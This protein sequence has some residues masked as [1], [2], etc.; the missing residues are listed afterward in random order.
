M[1]HQKAVIMS[2]RN[3]TMESISIS[4]SS[5]SSWSTWMYCFCYMPVSENYWI[6]F[7]YILYTLELRHLYRVLL[8]KT[9]HVYIVLGLPLGFTYYRHVD[10]R[11]AG[12]H[13]STEK[14]LKLSFLKFKVF[15]WSVTRI[16]SVRISTEHWLLS[17]LML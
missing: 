12:L 8:L 5:K 7:I 17:T 16:S 13:D 3:S 1:I 6:E 11:N 2:K 4:L 15:N 10:F 14:Q 9:V